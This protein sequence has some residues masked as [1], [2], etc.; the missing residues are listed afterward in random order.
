MILD[1]MKRLTL[2]VNMALAAIVLA[3]TWPEALA[4]PV[5]VGAA[6]VD[7]TP[8]YPVRLTGYASRV[9]ESEGVAQRLWAKALAV[10][11]DGGEGPALLITVENCGV[12]ADVTREV[13]TRL[14]AKAGVAPE[15]I[16]ICSSHTH[17]APCLLGFATNL[18]AEPVTAEQQQHMV[19]YKQQVVDWIEQAALGALAAR[20]PAQLSWAQGAVGFAMNRR[21]VKDG[22]CPGIGLQGEG[23]VDRSL[24]MLCAKDLQGK[25]V[26]IVVNYACHATTLGGDLNKIHGD[27][28]GVAQQCIEA[29]LPGAIALVSLGCGADANPHP[30]GDLD[31]VDRYGRA[32]AD[33]VKRLLRGKLTPLAPALSARQTRIGL[34]FNKLPTREE[35]HQQVAAAKAPKTD[36]TAKW[37]ASRATALLAQLDRDKSLPGEID[38]P[39]TVWAFGDDLAMVF[40][41]G[42]VVVDYVLRLK[43][44]LDGSRLWVAAYTNDVPCYIVSKRILDEG[45]YEPD[46]SMIYYGRPGPLSPVVEDRI[47]TAVKSLV[48]AGFAGK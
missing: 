17:S 44:E 42:E 26:A 40:L 1:T 45:G 12:P 31:K 23:P 6:R 34:P 14:K 18:L 13:G 36:G 29:D 43:R 30:R 2:L 33:E 3:G 8:D 48:P 25:V 27:W 16:A 32:V 19:R 5:P 4:Q 41:P 11:A 22:R 21:P 15:R 35:L 20:K 39:I 38:Y 28:P 7:I 47:V 9:K 37:K 10:G 24:P 46:S